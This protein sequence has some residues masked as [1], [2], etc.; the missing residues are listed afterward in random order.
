MG[1]GENKELDAEQVIARRERNMR[2]LWG[3]FNWYWGK[4]GSFWRAYWLFY[5][6]PLLE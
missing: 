5:G 3:Y 6:E 2:W 1:D 4:V